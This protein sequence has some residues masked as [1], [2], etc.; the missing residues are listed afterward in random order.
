MNNTKYKKGGDRICLDGVIA[1]LGERL[2]ELRR[3]K[4]LNQQQFAEL[5]G[6]SK[7]AVSNYERN[8]NEPDDEL[9]KRFAEF[10]NISMDYLLGLTRDEVPIRHTESSLI[11]FD[12]LPQAAKDEL[13]S[14]LEYFRKRYHL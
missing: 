9:K 13:A 3:G 5:M 12:N 7:N 4:K 8:I 6:I 14:F 11:Y 2:A 10:F 1:M